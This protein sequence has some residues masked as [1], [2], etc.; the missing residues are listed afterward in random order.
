VFS[1]KHNKKLPHNN[2]DHLNSRE[3]MQ[4]LRG[5]IKT[6]HAHACLDRLTAEAEAKK[7]G[8]SQITKTHDF[9]VI[10]AKCYAEAEPDRTRP[11]KGPNSINSTTIVWQ[12]ALHTPDDVFNK[13]VIVMRM[14]EEEQCLGQVEAQH[15]VPQSAAN[16]ETKRKRPAEAKRS[17]DSAPDVWKGGTT[18]PHISNPRLR[19]FYTA[20][21]LDHWRVLEKE[22]DEVIRLE[23]TCCTHSGFGCFRVFS[24]GFVCV[25]GVRYQR[26]YSHALTDDC[27]MHDACLYRLSIV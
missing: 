6:N 25:I 20:G 21:Q 17:V 1:A 18:R 23:S 13:I 27:L 22:L 4:S 11:T 9:K 26:S 10:K 16:R 7:Q 19:L 2:M 14:Y 3:L 24:S 15:E 5:S 8:A 12:I